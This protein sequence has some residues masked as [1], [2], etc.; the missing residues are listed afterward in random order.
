[1]DLVFLC[2]GAAAMMGAVGFVA[3]RLVRRRGRWAMA[4]VAPFFLLLSGLAGG[5]KLAALL[6]GA[7]EAHAQH[8]GALIA[9]MAAALVGWWIGLALSPPRREPK[10]DLTRYLFSME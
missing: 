3:A 6:S 10:N 4:L 9:A 5:L 8:G 7:P 1:M 2:L